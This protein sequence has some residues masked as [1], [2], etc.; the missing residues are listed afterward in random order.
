M[1][2]Q[3]LTIVLFIIGHVVLIVTTWVAIYTKITAKLKELEVRVHVMERQEDRVL[4]KLD[5]IQKD[6]SELK[7][8]IQNKQ[9]RI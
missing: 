5:N 7:S 2:D 3:Q 1:T 4:A 8:E 9:D 6:I